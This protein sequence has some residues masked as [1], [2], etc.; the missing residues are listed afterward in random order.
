MDWAK[1]FNGKA[2]AVVRRDDAPDNCCH[3]VFDVAA[4]LGARPTNFCAT[5]SLLDTPL[6]LSRGAS[7]PRSSQCATRCHDEWDKTDLEKQGEPSLFLRVENFR[8]LRVRVFI[9][10]VVVYGRV[11]GDGDRGPDQVLW[12][13][14]RHFLS[15]GLLYYWC[16]NMGEEQGGFPFSK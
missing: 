6:S 7:S 15:L 14:V 10:S 2:E 13:L 1:M 3:S 4:D 9:G 8:N 16:S 5:I 11:E 12:L